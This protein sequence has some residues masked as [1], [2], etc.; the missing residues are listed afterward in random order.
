M[1]RGQVWDTSPSTSLRGQTWVCSAVS[2]IHQIKKEFTTKKKLGFPY[3]DCL[4]RMS[5]IDPNSTRIS[6]ASMLEAMQNE[7]CTTRFD[8]KP[9]ESICAAPG[10]LGGVSGE[11]VELGRAR[12]RTSGTD[13]PDCGDAFR[14]IDASR[15]SARISPPAAMC[16]PAFPKLQAM[17]PIL[18]IRSPGRPSP[19]AAF[20]CAL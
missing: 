16:W 15:T 11:V 8:D 17:P 3:H 14:E 9:T 2:L 12:R 4:P 10:R 19:V 6:A 1:L 13:T 20:R 5:N 7:T 18:R